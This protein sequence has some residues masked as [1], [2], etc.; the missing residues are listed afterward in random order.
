MLND[1][2]LTWFLNQFA[3]MENIETEYFNNEISTISVMKYI[4]VKSYTVFNDNKAIPYCSS[5][6]SY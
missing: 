6:I 1:I 5:F 4:I 2:K 3:W